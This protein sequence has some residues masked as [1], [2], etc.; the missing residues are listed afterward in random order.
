MDA[1]MAIIGN[2]NFKILE[3]YL[4]IEVMEINII[5]LNCYKSYL[6]EERLVDR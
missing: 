6:Q 1:K 3:Q 4:E 2:F 5:N